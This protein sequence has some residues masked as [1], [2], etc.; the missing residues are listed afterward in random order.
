MINR[1]S[2]TSPESCGLPP[3]PVTRCQPLAIDQPIK[4][5]TAFG[6]IVT[7]VYAAITKEIVAKGAQARFVKAQR[8]Q[9]ALRGAAGPADP[10]LGASRAAEASA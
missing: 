1:T 7:A 10:L 9:F 5:Q 6:N 2:G 3:R 4:G 8:G